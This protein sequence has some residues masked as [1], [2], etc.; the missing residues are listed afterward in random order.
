MVQKAPDDCSRDIWMKCE[1]DELDKVTT[2]ALDKLVPESQE[3][4]RKI[5]WGHGLMCEINT[6][7]S[8]SSNISN[9]IRKTD[10]HLRQTDNHLTASFPGQPG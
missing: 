3:F 7:N 1:A 10:T 8:I 5:F 6:E 2:D 9:T 4:P